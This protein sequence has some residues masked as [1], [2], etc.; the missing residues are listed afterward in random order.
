M[1]TTSALSARIRMA[2]Y[3]RVPFE[4]RHMCIVSKLLGGGY[5]IYF[6]IPWVLGSEQVLGAL[7]VCAYP[8]KGISFLAWCADNAE[9]SLLYSSCERVR[10][11]VYVCADVLENFGAFFTCC[12]RECRGNTRQEEISC[13]SDA[14]R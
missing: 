1:E 5:F 10:K 14:G 3:C 7:S 11:T 12:H 13:Q 2:G 9:V 8:G 6:N 4:I